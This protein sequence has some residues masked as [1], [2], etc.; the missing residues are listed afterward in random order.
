MAEAK[1]PGGRRSVSAAVAGTLVVGWI[2]TAIVLVLASRLVEGLVHSGP[3]SRPGEWGVGRPLFMPAL[4]GG[5]SWIASVPV[6]LLGLT[7]FTLLVQSML[8]LRPGGSALP[9][10]PLACVLAATGGWAVVA[11]DRVSLLVPLVALLAAT[12]LVRRL[13]P[14]PAR[15][16]R[17]AATVALGVALGLLAVPVAYGALHPL[18]PAYASCGTGCEK[19]GF[20]L[21]N[22]G[23]FS[24]T[25]LGV[26][27]E[28]Q[29]GLKPGP[30]QIDGAR[31]LDSGESVQVLAPLGLGP[32]ACPAFAT[33]G[34]GEIGVRVRY[35]VRD[36]I[37]RKRMA[38]RLGYC[39][40]AP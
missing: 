6:A 12:F 26:E 13:R 9:V 11:G 21:R 24:V 35:R 4:P 33:T 10:R 8:A 30:A 2:A 23:P 19:V 22:Q 20:A 1:R 29:E 28:R 18:D 32:G 15:V 39:P 40:G 31:R 17:R 25:V 38:I 16:G 27:L 3:G 37:I 14:G 36:R 7:V 34:I 5:G